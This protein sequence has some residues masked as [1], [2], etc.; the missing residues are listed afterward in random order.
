[1]SN[2]LRSSGSFISRRAIRSLTSLLSP[3][4][5]CDNIIKSLKCK[6]L[7]E[8]DVP[9]T[10][11]LKAGIMTA[12]DAFSEEG[13]PAVSARDFSLLWQEIYYDFHTVL[14]LYEK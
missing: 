10:E 9:E 8:E 2:C 11:A 12:V 7:T 6:G 3:E 13:Y 14:F 5:Q 1:M 4:Q